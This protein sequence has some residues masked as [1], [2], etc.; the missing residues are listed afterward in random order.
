MAGDPD[1]F[2]RFRNAYIVSIRARHRW[3]A[4]RP[5][6]RYRP[7]WRACF[8]P[9]PPSMA[10]DPSYKDVSTYHIS[11]FQSAP[12]IDGGR[13][14]AAPFNL[15]VVAQVSIRARHRWRAI[16]DHLYVLRVGRAVSIRARHR[17]RAI[18]SGRA[19]ADDRRLVSIRAR[20]R[21]RA[22]RVSAFHLPQTRQVSIRARHRWRAIPEGVRGGAMLE[23]FQSAPAIDGGRS[24]GRCDRFGLQDRFNPRPP[25]MAGDPP[26]RSATNSWPR[27]SIRA[28]HRWRAIRGPDEAAR[29]VASFQS[30]P[31]IDGGRSNSTRRGLSEETCFNPRPP[32][33]AGDPNLPDKPEKL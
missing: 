20:H 32:S 33:M 27:V 19:D 13:S 14:H 9:R 26:N 22:I 12:A 29:P 1:G 16:R 17:W 6:C 5:R 15:C 10:G 31:A 25:S 11:W 2:R 7:F 4:I 21:W 8:N 3:R 23:K 24:L 18:R 30:A 28:R